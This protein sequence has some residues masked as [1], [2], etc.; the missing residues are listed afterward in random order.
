MANACGA[1]SIWIELSL[2]Q[3]INLNWT[4]RAIQSLPLEKCADLERTKRRAAQVFNKYIKKLCPLYERLE[5]F[6][7]EGCL[8]AASFFFSFCTNH[9]LLILHMSE[10]SFYF[11]SLSKQLRSVIFKRL[12]EHWARV[13]GK[14]RCLKKEPN[15]THYTSARLKV[16][17]LRSSKWR[18]AIRYLNAGCWC[19]IHLQ[20]LISS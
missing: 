9:G 10:D 11:I 19:W 7:L 2:A 16:N 4:P 6:S 15:I 14:W 5:F 1:R 12:T 13:W 8:Q 18:R 3:E 20:S 17:M